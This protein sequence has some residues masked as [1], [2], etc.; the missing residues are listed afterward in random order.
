[1]WIDSDISLSI[2]IFKKVWDTADKDLKPIVSGIYF[3][4]KSKDDELM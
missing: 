3:I 1:L 2:D 4:S